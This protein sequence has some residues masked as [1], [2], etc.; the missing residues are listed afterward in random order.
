LGAITQDGKKKKK[1]CGHERP[2]AAAPIVAAV[3]GG[4]NERNKR[5][6]PQGGNNGTCPVHPNSRH[7]ATE[8]HEII[9]LAKRVSERREQASKD[10]SCNAPNFELNFFF[11]YRSL[12]SGVTSLSYFFSL[13][14]YLFPKLQVV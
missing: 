13:K 7:I 2:Q 5:P 14:P 11:L 6:R 12:N 9:K 10:G 8:C 4:R 1:N 3:T